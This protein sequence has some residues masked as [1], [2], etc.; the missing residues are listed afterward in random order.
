MK[1]VIP[2]ID[3]DLIKSELTEER[4]LKH[5][6]K[7]NNQLYLVDYHNARNTV[8]EIG[9]LREQTFRDAGGGT[10]KEYDLD[11]Y[12]TS[13]YAFTQLIV[14]DPESEEL[15]AGYRL[16][17]CSKAEKDENGMIKTPTSKLFDL[18]EGFYNNYLD[19]TL[20]LGRSFVQTQFQKKNVTQK[21]IYALDNLWDG[22]GAYML[23]HPELKHFFGKV[24]MYPDYHR[25]AR[26]I[27]LSFLHYFFPDDEH[28][29]KPRKAYVKIEEISP[30]LT[31]WDKEDY[32]SS[33]R[34]LNRE[35][36]AREESIPPLINS[37]M[38]LSHS[39]KTFG[40]ALNSGFGDVEETAL[41]ITV[42][43]MYE[44]RRER[45]MSPFKHLSRYIGPEKS[46]NSFSSE[47][48]NS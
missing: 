30:F 32:K 10:G 15:L 3:R 34:T 1:K 48:S 18:L 19:S 14:W 25:E 42:E 7:G 33:Y 11:D 31:W 37:Y 46:W 2:R 5:T 39:M 6:N 20:E 27:L 29:I 40:T 47:S 35:I 13:D 38:N 17:E 36:R 16:L 21:N 8:L 9:R 23:I 28:I 26:N 45:Y 43:D 24:T 4:F 41:L 22:L 44:N 12:D